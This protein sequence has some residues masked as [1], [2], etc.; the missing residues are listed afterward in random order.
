MKVRILHVIAIS[1]GVF[2]S[3]AIYVAEATAG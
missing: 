3:M 2:A 1:A